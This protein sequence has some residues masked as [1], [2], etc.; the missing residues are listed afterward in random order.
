MM[1]SNSKK[2]RQHY[3]PQFYLKGFSREY[4]KPEDKRNDSKYNVW[5]YD[6]AKRK[7]INRHVKKVAQE[8]Y[9]YSWITQD[10]DWD[11]TL[12]EILSEVETILAP[13]IKFLN[14]QIVEIQKTKKKISH[15]IISENQ[16]YNLLEFLRITYARIPSTIE[17][18]RNSIKKDFENNSSGKN[19]DE[20]ILK[21]IT[22]ETA[23]Q[24][25]TSK[26]DFV[27]IFDSRQLWILYP[28]SRLGSIITTD[29]PIVRFN[30]NGPNGIGYPDTEIYYPLS[31]NFVLVIMDKENDKSKLHVRAFN[32]RNELSK[33]NR[34]V[35]QHATKYLIGRDRDLIQSIVERIKFIKPK[36]YVEE[37][38][39]DTENI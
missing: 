26:Y 21:Q 18:M 4:L 31:Q 30:K 13:F 7:I 29:S 16:R 19:I 38:M 24:L 10:G 9:Y 37:M 3:L 14:D 25:G 34:Y 32:D 8:S 6:L 17:P 27:E 11:Y 36:K 20:N 39:D 28:Q 35:A 2:K 22:L 1:M 23:M 15:F 12:E 5:Y 33:Y